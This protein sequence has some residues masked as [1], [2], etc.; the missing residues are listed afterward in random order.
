MGIDAL[1]ALMRA[2]FINF[3]IN[4]DTASYVAT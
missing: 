4:F 1:R 2:V 3:S